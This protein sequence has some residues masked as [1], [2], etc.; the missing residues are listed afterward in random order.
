VPDFKQQ[1][2]ELSNWGRWGASDEKGALNYITDAKRRAAAQLVRKGRTFSLAIPMR[3]GSGPQMGAGGRVNPLHFMTATGC[4]PAGKIELG[5]GCRYTDDFLA[6]TVQGGTQWDGLCHIYYGDKLYNG[7]P[8]SCV[9][10]SG[11]A[12]NGIDKVHADFVSRGVLLD[13]ARLRG[14]DCLPEG[15]AIPIAELEEAERRQKV[16]VEEGDILLVR[17]GQMSTV[18]D[19]ENWSAFRRKEAGMHWETAEWLHQR[20]V[21]AIAADNSMVEAGG[22]LPGV[23]VPFHM[24]AL[25][26]LGIHL[27]EFWY[28]E[29]LAADCAADSVWD[30]M[31]VAQALPI[32]GGTG[33][34]VNP[35]AIK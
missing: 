19:F 34:P 33:S 18:G 7:H 35:L 25:S 8:A 6:F 9:D 4:D 32:A 30:F 10:S 24:L 26:N 11:A 21:A 5:E 15:H 28:L 20:R 13:I 16:R 2:R 22:V 3:N 17:T 31:L 12:L 14:V 1:L 27:G 23:M 29:E